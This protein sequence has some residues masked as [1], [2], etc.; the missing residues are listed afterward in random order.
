MAGF[1][2]RNRR[3]NMVS[4]LGDRLQKILKLGMEYDDLVISQSKAIGVTQGQFAQEVSLPDEMLYALAAADIGQ[5][6]YIAYFDK[7]YAGRR[8]FL[9]NFAMNGEIEW[10]LDTLADEAVVYDSRNFFCRPDISN[11]SGD[12]TDTMYHE[13]S[14][15]INN[16]FKKIYSFFRFNTGHS[17]WSYFRQLLIDGFIA[18]EIIYDEDQRNIIAFKELDAIT[19]SPETI[20]DES[21]NFTQGWVQFPE[22]PSLKRSIPD[23]NLIYISFAN[24]NFTSRLSYLERL[25]R[26]FNLLRM[27]E[28]TRVIWNLM[29]STYRLKI[30]VPV[31]NIRSKQAMAQTIG[32]VRSM[33][34]EEIR[35]DQN[36]GELM[37][38][39]TANIQ[40]FKNYI[41]PT[42]GGESPEV[43]VLS[44]EGPDLSDL[45]QVKYYY[46]K[47][48]VDSKIPFQRWSREEGGGGTTIFGPEGVEREE[49]R[50]GTFINRLQSIYQEIIIKPL[51]I[52]TCLDKPEFIGD[53]LF[54]TNIGIIFER[55]NLFKLLKDIDVKTRVLTFISA[56][57]EYKEDDGDT[58]VFSSR[59]LLEKYMDFDYDDLRQNRKYLKIDKKRL[60]DEKKETEGSD[61]D[62]KDGGNAIK[63]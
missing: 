10:I 53:E 47:L 44:P 11:L 25:F 38:N 19:L 31:G 49:I 35:L 27:M 39:G 43:T 18:F 22:I 28:N 32:N 52:Q 24:G 62:K 23:T 30:T 40:F 41:M 46:D 16:N 20:K 4:S 9:R 14:K 13:L 29:N 15:L 59:W 3:N 55:N 61:D 17:A 58:A 37:V 26:S 42:K 45:N 6:K 5:K 33:F 63:F 36:S 57:K 2:S 56:M 21:G 7:D 54:K 1:L 8:A 60:A 51:Y 12:L 34:K 48:K 50:F